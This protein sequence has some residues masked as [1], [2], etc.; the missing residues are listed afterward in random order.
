M[1]SSRFLTGVVLIFWVFSGLASK[2]YSVSFV[3]W[4][5]SIMFMSNI[6]SCE[7]G[8]WDF[9]PSVPFPSLNVLSIVVFWCLM[10]LMLPSLLLRAST[11]YLYIPSK[12]WKINM[13][14]EILA[15]VLFIHNSDFLFIVKF[16]RTNAPLP[17]SS[18][19]VQLSQS[20]AF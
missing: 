18:V 9:F 4:S 6:W 15:S 11:A 14:L 3:A 7:E 8:K 20:E 16:S 19:N 12:T 13:L 1:Q 2:G 10:E 17:F 5:T